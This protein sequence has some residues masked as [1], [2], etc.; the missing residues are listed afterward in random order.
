MTTHDEAA[1]RGE[2]APE[3]DT[4][5]QLA[6]YI[7]SKIDG[8]HD[9]GTCVYAMSLAAV[10][11]YNLVARKL[12]VTGFQASMADLDIVRRTRRIKGP[13]MLVDANKMLY[14][15]YS[16]PGDL[17]KALDKWMPW[18]AEE[19]KKKLADS[20]DAHP[21]VIRHWQALAANATP[22]KAAP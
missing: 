9:Y 20:P 7:Q 2:E 5:E 4:V 19:A 12:E 21:D 17:S 10:A 15:Q 13:F 8:Q 1:M 14:P 18:A 6:A 3:C 16:L 22:E 11:A